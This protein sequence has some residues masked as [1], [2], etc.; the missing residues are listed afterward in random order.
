MAPDNQTV[1]RVGSIGVDV[2]ILEWRIFRTFSVNQ[3]SALGVQFYAGFDRP[4]SSS[5]VEPVGA[6]KP[7]LHTIVTGGVR[8]VFDWRHYHH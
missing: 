4:T 8:V 7:N 2:P 6:P 3:S 5:V 1:V